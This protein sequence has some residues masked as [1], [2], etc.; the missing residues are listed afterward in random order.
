LVCSGEELQSV[1]GLG[2]ALKCCAYKTEDATKVTLLKG[3]QERGCSLLSALKIS[4]NQNVFL[5][6]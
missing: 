5:C 2:N 4:F 6:S 3:S 1:L